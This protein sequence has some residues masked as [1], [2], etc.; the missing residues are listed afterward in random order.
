MNL[1]NLRLLVPWLLCLSLAFAIS[2]APVAA[3]DHPRDVSCPIQAELSIE[4]LDFGSVLDQAQV[5]DGSNGCVISCVNL[6]DCASSGS[7]LPPLSSAVLVVAATAW[8]STSPERLE[9]PPRV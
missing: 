1:I 2:L 3:D 9:R 8:M 6:A 4:M 7:T 5:E